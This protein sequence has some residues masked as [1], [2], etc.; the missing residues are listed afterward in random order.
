MK[1]ALLTLVIIGTASASYA[2]TNIFEAGSNVG[3]GIRDPS[4]KLEISSQ[5]N[6][7][8][9]VISRNILAGNEGPGITFKN[10]INGGMLEKIGGIES[11]LR[12]G[13]TGAVG[14]SLNFFTIN[15]SKKINAM[16]ITAAGSV[17]IGTATPS[18]GLEVVDRSNGDQL[19]ISRNILGANEGP[20][21]TFKNIVNSG[22]LEKIGGIEGQ[23][24]SGTTG[25]VA[26]SL[27]LFTFNN[28]AKVD[29]IS[30]AYNGDVGIGT[31][32]T[33]GYKLAVNGKIRASEILVE[34]TN[35]PDY[36]FE[37]K[38]DLISLTEL[39]NFIDQNKHLPEFPSAQEV[40]KNGISLGEIVKV[41][42][43]KIEELTLYLIEKDKQFDSLQRDSLKQQAQINELQAQFS[44][45]LSQQ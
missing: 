31:P 20:G 3:I 40:T 12:S 10:I 8:Q 23:L 44:K 6:G 33:R 19:I 45:L 32:D 1:K 15:D 22:T 34:A 11:Q 35:W 9:L 16:S 26:G 42:T 37:P 2:Q 29:A 27:N 4:G 36:V 7:D 18:G 17:G 28:S 41:Q 25:A 13:T 39:K 14:G 30:V 38:Y 5:Y 24:K 21:I 43:K